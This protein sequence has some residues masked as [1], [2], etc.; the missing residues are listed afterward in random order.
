MLIV[1]RE[2][3]RHE[4]TW[5]ETR[6]GIAM[7]ITTYSRRSIALVVYC[8]HYKIACPIVLELGAMMGYLVPIALPCNCKAFQ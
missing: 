7:E 2:C 5:M 4:K 1:D 8:R 6:I 3:E